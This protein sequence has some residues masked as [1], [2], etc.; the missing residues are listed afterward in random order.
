MVNLSKWKLPYFALFFA[1]LIGA[2]SF[3]RAKK[4][5]SPDFKVFYTATQ[6]AIHNPEVMYQKS[7]DRYLYPPQATVFFLPFA[8]SSFFS[9]HQW[10][11]HFFLIFCL[12]FL[13]RGSWAGLVSMLLL[14]RYLLITFGYGQ[15]NLVLIAALM[16]LA[17]INS[18]FW[19]GFLWAAASVIKLYPLVFGLGFLLQKAKKTIIVALGSFLVLTLLPLFYLR[20]HPFFLYQEFFRSLTEK[21]FPLHSH[22]Q[23]ISALFQRLLTDQSF[24]LHAVG[25]E[26]WAFFHLDINLVKVLA[27]IVGAGLSFCCWRVAYLSNR[28][29]INFSYLSAGALSILFLSHIVWK[30]YLL[31]LYFPLV[32][33]FSLHKQKA[34]QNTAVFVLLFVTLVSSPDVI[35]APIATRLD[36]ASIHLW[37][38]VFIALIWMKTLLRIEGR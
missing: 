38:A 5:E 17:N 24:P 32:Q 3:H 14:S 35:G 7:P 10:Q 1:L 30:D 22:N 26:K 23:S 27:L 13:V 25:L 8:F 6:Y 21:G 19:K 12:W 29:D 36:A 33:I 28:K 15:V 31:F 20:D 4:L 18:T 9:L 34:W 2:L 11:W 37:G 16:L